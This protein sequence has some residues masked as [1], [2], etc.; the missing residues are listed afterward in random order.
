MISKNP[1]LNIVKN[2]N[3]EIRYSHNSQFFRSDSI[4]GWS[5]GKSEKYYTAFS[6]LLCIYTK[7]D[8]I[9]K[10]HENGKRNNLYKKN[11][12]KKETKSIFEWN[13]G[14]KD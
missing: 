2:A 7:F 9:S 6:P 4:R 1:A 8:A 5:V 10:Y 3:V 13:N 14:F 11:H 12:W